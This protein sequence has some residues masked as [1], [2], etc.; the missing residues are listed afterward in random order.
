[1]TKLLDG[2]ALALKLRET[3]KE[4]IN[5]E[6][7]LKNRAMP[8]IVIINVGNNKNSQ[9]YITGK[10]K[11]CQMLGIKTTLEHFNIIPTQ[12]HLNSVIEKH[13]NNP[14]VDGILVQLPLPPGLNATEAINKIAP[15]KDI[16]GLTFVNLGKLIS[17]EPSAVLSCTP[18][19]VIELV[20]SYG[21]G[22][23]GKS[24]ALVNRSLL[25]GKPLAQ[26][27]TQNDATVTVC[28]TKTKDL[29]HILKSSDIIITAVGL[30]NFVKAEHVKKGTVVIDIGLTFDKDEGKVFGDCDYEN[31]KDLCSYI[32]P[33]PGGVG[34]MTITMLI[35]N[36][37][38]LAIQHR[39][40][41][42]AASKQKDSNN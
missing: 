38:T 6:F 26:L 34:P 2:A 19:G 23:C 36:L 40:A 25:V 5:S 30:K 37:I 3:L 13:N 9:M 27:L 24:V 31:I 33:V 15:D 1:M 10:F 4:T 20:K 35:K 7:A 12:Q 11:A 17:G 8:H 39:E 21:V 14:G 41:I 32:T 42:E 16:D 29:D 22:L 28:H 18:Q